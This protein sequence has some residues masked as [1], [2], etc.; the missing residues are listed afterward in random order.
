MS[1]TL[2]VEQLVVPV[3]RVLGEREVHI[4]C[5]CRLSGGAN[6]QTWSL[7]ARTAELS[8][9][10]I[11]R[12]KPMGVGQEAHSIPA[13]TGAVDQ[14]PN[15][16]SISALSL[17]TE[18]SLIS[19]AAA[20]GV[21]VPRVW[22]VLEDHENLGEGMLLERLDGEAVPPRILRDPKLERA[23]GSFAREVGKELARL[24]AAPIDRCPSQLRNISWEADLQRLQSLS[25]HFRNP[26]PVH[27]LAINWLREQSAPQSPRVLCHG[28]FRLGNILMDE[29]GVVSILDWELAHVGYAG[30]DLGYLCANVWRFGGTKP[31]AGLGDYE[32][33]LE[34]YTKHGGSSITM[35]E[36]HLWQVYAALG[37]G[38]SC[39]TM[40]ELHLSGEDPG[41]ERAA[42]GRRLSES[43]ID[44]LLLLEGR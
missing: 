26:S 20:M 34:S 22:G 6:M 9:P 38:F 27:Q 37:W 19:L 28:D 39:L 18:A 21:K 36:L 41:L 30:E 3:S 13:S 25:D 8:Y 1:E 40:L 31:V 11:L 17:S 43:E 23:R 4:D 32:S 44:I 42:V 7:D 10:L 35:E 24:H 33:L 5:L 12:R 29:T 2:Q 16:I 15:P 14:R